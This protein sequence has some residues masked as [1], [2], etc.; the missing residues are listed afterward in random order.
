MD[1]I[2]LPLAREQYQSDLWVGSFTFP[3]VFM[4]FVCVCVCVCV[5]WLLFMSS[6]SVLGSAV[7][8]GGGHVT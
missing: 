6:V 2:Q 4:S 8:E 3:A 5:C 7:H 1:A